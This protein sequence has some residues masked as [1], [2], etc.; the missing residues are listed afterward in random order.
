MAGTSPRRA[1]VAAVTASALFLSSTPLPAQAALVST[2]SVVAAQADAADRAKVESFLAREDVAA[3]MRSMGV[4]PDEAR[5][6]VAS[7]SDSELRQ[8]AGRIDELPAGG[9]AIGVVIGAALLI[10]I[11]LLITD[12]AGLTKVFPWTRSIR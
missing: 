8:I 2:D 1:L 11:V 6:R 12:I 4:S 10:F 5:A 3:Q 7:M 9:S